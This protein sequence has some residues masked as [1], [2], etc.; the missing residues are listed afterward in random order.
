MDFLFQIK[1]FETEWSGEDD[2]DDDDDDDDDDDNDDDAK[3]EATAINTSRKTESFPG[4]RP[5]ENGILPASLAIGRAKMVITG[6]EIEGER[7]QGKD[8]F[9]TR[10]FSPPL[11]ID[12]EDD[13][14]ADFDVSFDLPQGIYTRLELQFHVGNENHPSFE[15]SGPVNGNRPERIDFKFHYKNREKIRTR[16]LRNNQVSENIVVD[17]SKETRAIIIIDTE[18]LFANITRDHLI[19]SQAAGPPQGKP[20]I[21]VDKKSNTHIYGAL[22]NRIEKSIAVVFE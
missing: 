2:E 7:E 16:A 9:I 6:I 8:V 13:E 20:F 11:E 19:N 15:F 3:G 4:K 21:M 18:Y 22:A 10:D 14:T 17:K 12:L 5:F 1:P